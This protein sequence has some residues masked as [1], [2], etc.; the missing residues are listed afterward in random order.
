MVYK[1]RSMLPADTILR[2]ANDPLEHD[3]ITWLG[4]FCR[5]LRLDEIPQ[6]INVLKGEMSLIGPRPDY[7]P[8]AQEYLL[9]IPR[10]RLRHTVRPGISGFA[11]TEVGY[12]SNIAGTKK[13]VAADLLYIKHAGFCLD[14]YLL[15]RTFQT[16][17][18]R[19]GM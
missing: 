18:T 2:G 11:Q 5:K 10:Y 6:I 8:H 13:K 15:W 16:V 4:A 9:H 17:L 1:F 3:R 12:V 19:Q 14:T 7:Y